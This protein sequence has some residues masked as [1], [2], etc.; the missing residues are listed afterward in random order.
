MPGRPFHPNVMFVV[1]SRRLR[2]AP[3]LLA[4][5][6]TRLE[7]LAKDNSILVGPF[8]SYKECSVNFTPG[9]C[10]EAFYDRN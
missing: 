2:Q 5:H 1:K 10:H 7:T 3:T 4:K 9:L 6:K 8:V